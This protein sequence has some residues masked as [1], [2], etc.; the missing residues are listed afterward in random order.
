MDEFLV[1]NHLLFLVIPSLENEIIKYQSKKIQLPQF[2]KNSSAQ[3]ATE[4]DDYKAS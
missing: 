4:H 3:R 2:D 1:L